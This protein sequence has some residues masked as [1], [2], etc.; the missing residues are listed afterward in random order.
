MGP[1]NTNVCFQ[2]PVWFAPTATIYTNCLTLAITTSPSLLGVLF[3]LMANPK[4]LNIQHV[5]CVLLPQHKKT[6]QNKVLENPEECLISQSEGG[7]TLT[8]QQCVLN[9]TGTHLCLPKLAAL[10]CTQKGS[11]LSM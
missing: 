10:I 1:L 11:P 9:L 2:P 3:K 5:F 8:A 7:L 4:Y 6:D